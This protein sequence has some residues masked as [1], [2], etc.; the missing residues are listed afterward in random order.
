MARRR[1]ENKKRTPESTTR[2]RKRRSPHR[3]RDSEREAQE[4][5]VANIRKLVVFLL[6]AGL[7]ML[8]ANKILVRAWHKRIQAQKNRP[9]TTAVITTNKAVA[10][11]NEAA[12]AEDAEVL[13]D[14]ILL[15]RARQYKDRG[16]L[17]AAVETYEVLIE[18][19]TVSS[20]IMHEVTG[21]LLKSGHY[22]EAREKLTEWVK[23]KPDDIRALN[24]LG[25][26]HLLMNHA[27]AAGDL[28]GS[29]LELDED[30][31]EARYN[32][33]LA[34]RRMG[35]GEKAKATVDHFIERQPEDPR[36]LRLKAL[37][38]TADGLYDEALQLLDQTLDLRPDW[39]KAHMD[40]ASVAAMA[41]QNDRAVAHLRNVSKLSSPGQA[42]RFYRTRVFNNLR[43]SEAGAA[44]EK[45]IVKDVKAAFGKAQ[46][47]QTITASE[48]PLWS[49]RPAPNETE[50]TEPATETTTEPANEPAP[51]ESADTTE[52]T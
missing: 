6:L 32:L 42:Y 33:A 34:Q 30:F 15:T 51:E 28:F 50:P 23:Q 2:R 38:V 46:I 24:N 4:S 16:L 17:E 36:G 40:A 7:A 27:D 41:G 37:L 12:L 8:G 3:R 44:F 11:T 26:I 18:Q 21:V 43:D 49:D 29:A 10:V 45:D 52:S 22:R 31:D 48:E 35:R 1:S 9:Q 20:D 14:E 13:T 19:G 39:P 47:M 25:V 5:F